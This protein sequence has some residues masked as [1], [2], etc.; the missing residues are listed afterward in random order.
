M[1]DKEKILYICNNKNIS[2]LQECF[3]W[4]EC[5]KSALK[6]EVKVKAKNDGIETPYAVIDFVRRKPLFTSKYD[7]VFSSQKQEKDALLFALAI[8]KDY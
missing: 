2:F 5:L 6:G 3:G 8:G 7:Y 1:D 4:Y